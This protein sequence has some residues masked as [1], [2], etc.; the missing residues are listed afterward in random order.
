MPLAPAASIRH[1][2]PVHEPARDG[3][4]RTQ[5]TATRPF[6]SRGCAAAV[7]WGEMPAR[8]GRM[9]GRFTQRFSWREVH[10]L[11]SLTGPAL[12]LRPR[13]NV[14]PTQD[15][16]AVRAGEDGRRALDAAVGS[17][18]ELG[19]GPA[20]GFEAHQRQGRDREHEALVPC[21]VPRPSLPHSSR[22]VLRV[23]GPGVGPAAVADR[24]RGR[25]AVRPSPGCGSGGRFRRA[26]SSPDRC[27][28]T[29]PATSWRPARFSR[30]PPM[31]R[32]LRFITGCPSSF[33]RKRSVPGSAARA[34]RSSPTRRRP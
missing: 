7:T 9:C 18:P 6:S 13:Y 14:A 15:V 8:V 5:L 11:L 31:R 16:A 24:T 21:R 20:H 19:Q 28:P 3:P 25:R 34:L 2:G 4:C 17:P 32:W 1:P 33:L 30:P 27:P 22:R 23:D 10:A 29:G 26:S 12:N